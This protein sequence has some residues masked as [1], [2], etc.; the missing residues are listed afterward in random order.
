M[1]IIAD[2]S[3]A[4]GLA[5]QCPET[6]RFH[7]SSNFLLWIRTE[8]SAL[9]D[10]HAQILSQNITTVILSPV[11]K[12]STYFSL[13][14]EGPGLLSS[15]FPQHWDLPSSHW[16]NSIKSGHFPALSIPQSSGN[17]TI[18]ITT[19]A[20]TSLVPICIL[21]SFCCCDRGWHHDQK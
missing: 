14:W 20:S 10:Q 13:K 21:A 6:H 7:L 3:A 4:D 18:M 19:A 5:F 9:G 8:F 17:N 15:H 11:P 2:F 12:E 16:N 1:L